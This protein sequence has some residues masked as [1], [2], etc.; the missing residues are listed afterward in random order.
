MKNIKKEKLFLMLAIF[1]IS[2]VT[3]G[4]SYAAFTYFG[5]GQKEN[6]V[7]T[8]NLTFNYDE[9][10]TTSV[11]IQNAFPMS[12]ENGKKQENYFEFSVEASTKGAPIYY[13]IY[14]EKVDTS[15]LDEKVVKTYLTSLNG[16][17]EVEEKDPVNN[18]VINFYNK[19][20]NSQVPNQTNG[21]TLYQEV[22]PEGESN[23]SK[24]FR[25][26]MWIDENASEVNEDGEWIYNNKTFTVRVNVYASNDSIGKASSSLFPRMKSYA[27]VD[28]DFHT[29]DCWSETVCEWS[30]A[31]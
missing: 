19:L 9:N 15:T 23:Y 7:S 13:E 20:G 22:I 3:V 31:I 27:E 16:E 11:S 26:R 10:T 4:L 29:L 6:L 21:K 5:S 8:G 17:E 24:T 18:K 2:L 30:H 25:Y 1:G 12:D 14:L 28:E